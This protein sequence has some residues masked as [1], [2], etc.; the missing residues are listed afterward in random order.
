MY[1]KA[2]TSLQFRKLAMA[3]A[4]WLESLVVVYKDNSPSHTMI[5]VRGV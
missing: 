1:C 4:G 2:S 5:Y 3:F